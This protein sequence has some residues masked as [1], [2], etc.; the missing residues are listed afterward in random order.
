MYLHQQ[1]KYVYCINYTYKV[2]Q[3]EETKE[4]KDIVYEQLLNMSTHK[5]MFLN[6]SMLLNSVA[7]VFLSIK[8][9]CLT[10]YISLSLKS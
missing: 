8:N 5:S 7:V 10:Y 3:P 2:L 9:F 6:L 4:N 1:N